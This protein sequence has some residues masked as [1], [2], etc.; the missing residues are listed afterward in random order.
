VLDPQTFDGRLRYRDRAGVL[1]RRPQ[2]VDIL[3]GAQQVDA[4]V[5]PD[6]A[7]TNAASRHLD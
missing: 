6:R 4:H 7:G 2:R 1:E 3:R 5:G